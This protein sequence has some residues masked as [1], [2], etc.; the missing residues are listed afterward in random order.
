LTPRI[1]QK[2]ETDENEV[3]KS[4]AAKQVH[5]DNVVSQEADAG[6][7]NAKRTGRA[8]EPD[9]L[10]VVRLVLLSRQIDRVEEE[11]LEPQGKTNL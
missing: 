1:F 4:E 9:W 3:I 6:A 5:L 8:F 7:K 2:L 11:Q 10:K